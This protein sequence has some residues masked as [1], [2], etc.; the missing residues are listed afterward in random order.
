MLLRGPALSAG[1]PF[2]AILHPPYSCPCPLICS[3]LC[4][5]LRYSVLCNTLP[6]SPQ[7]LGYVRNLQC[8]TRTLRRRPLPPALH[9]EHLSLLASSLGAGL[10]L[11]I[12]APLLI[13]LQSQPLQPTLKHSNVAACRLPP[14]VCQGACQGACQDLLHK[15][16]LLHEPVKPAFQVVHQ[17]ALRSMRTQSKKAMPLPWLHLQSLPSLAG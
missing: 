15:R 7:G 11:A 4:L 5:S 6:R 14:W 17:T 3:N 10:V 8:L 2:T 13:R 9:G 16:P 12:A 1:P